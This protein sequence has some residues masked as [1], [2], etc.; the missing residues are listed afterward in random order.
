V[1]SAGFVRLESLILISAPESHHALNLLNL[2][3]HLP[4][5]SPEPPDSTAV[6]LHAGLRWRRSSSQ[7]LS[8]DGAGTESDDDDSHQ[9]EQPAQLFF[10]V[11]AQL[12]APPLPP[13][14]QPR[15]RSEMPAELLFDSLHVLGFCMPLRACRP[16]A[17]LCI[18]PVRREA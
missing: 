11:E 4:A 13:D 17:P 3:S 10:V 18:A 8:S 12:D 9:L 5:S 15:L 6:L 7:R 14:P 1:K 16:R 2:R